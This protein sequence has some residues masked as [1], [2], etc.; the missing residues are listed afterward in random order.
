M[1]GFSNL[2]H[3]GQMNIAELVKSH[4]EYCAQ[5]SRE[6]SFEDAY[7]GKRL[8]NKEIDKLYKSSKYI[9]SKL[10]FEETVVKCFVIIEK[11]K[12]LSSD[13]SLEELNGMLE[14]GVVYYLSGHDNS[15]NEFY[16]KPP[17]IKSPDGHVVRSNAE[18][19]IDL[20][21]NYHSIKHEY[22][23]R[24]NTSKKNYIVADFYLPEY[25]CYL[26][27]WGL[28]GDTDYEKRKASKID[29]YK[30]LNLRL[31]S[32]YQDDLKNLDALLME[33]MLP[34]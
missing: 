5:L 11:M 22:E 32:I 33:I 7:D 30:S 29:T 15:I 18:L 19:I 21:L 20:W 8:L 23:P 2:A 28:D 13:W 17:K 12:F 24:I 31:V 3:T 26:E 14:G 25:D 16:R 10:H 34:S 9:R 1:R 27:Y 6:L 4:S